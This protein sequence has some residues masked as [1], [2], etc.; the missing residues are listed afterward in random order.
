MIK[1]SVDRL[2]N[3]QP[4]IY[5]DGP[6]LCI[7]LHRECI[8]IDRNGALVWVMDGKIELENE[9]GLAECEVSFAKVEDNAMG[10]T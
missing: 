10:G 6:G 2:G 5:L 7:V 3:G 8:T 4:V 9:D 1:V